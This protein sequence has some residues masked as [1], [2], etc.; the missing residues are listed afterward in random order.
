MDPFVLDPLT[1]ACMLALVNFVEEGSKLEIEDNYIH[2]TKP[3]AVATGVRFIF[4]CIREGYSREALAHLR[5]PIARSI[6]WYKD[7]APT[8]FENAG[9]GL[10]KLIDTYK[11]KTSLATETLTLCLLTVEKHEDIPALLHLPGDEVRQDQLHR[12]RD[13]WSDAE[14]LCLE[15]WFAQLAA[16][17]GPREQHIRSIRE[18]LHLKQPLLREVIRDTAV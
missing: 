15:G 5:K 4:S 13:M 1:T 12:L 11:G 9:L 6:M 17:S 2:F 10:R 18:F 7:T 3:S 16:E 8:V 14:V